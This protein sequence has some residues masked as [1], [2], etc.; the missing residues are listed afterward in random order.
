MVAHM[1][2]IHGVEAPVGL[3]ADRRYAKDFP[4]FPDKDFESTGDIEVSE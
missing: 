2:R 4:G 1:K 3:T